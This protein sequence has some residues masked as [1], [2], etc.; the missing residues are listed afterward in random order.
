MVCA[1]ETAL[2]ASVDVIKPPGPTRLTIY[3]EFVE[4]MMLA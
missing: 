4:D 3:V 1:E 2:L